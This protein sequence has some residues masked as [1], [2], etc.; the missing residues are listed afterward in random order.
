MIVCVWGLR[1]LGALYG[2]HFFPNI[3]LKKN[4]PHSLYGSALAHRGVVKAKLTSL[5]SASAVLKVPVRRIVSLSKPGRPLCLGAALTT[6]YRSHGLDSSVLYDIAY[7]SQNIGGTALTAVV[8]SRSGTT[9]SFLSPIIAFYWNLR[10]GRESVDLL[11]YVKR[12]HWQSRLWHQTLHSPRLSF[13]A[14]IFLVLGTIYVKIVDFFK[15]PQFND[16]AFKLWNFSFGGVYLIYLIVKKIALVF[17]NI[18]YIPVLLVFLFRYF[19]YLYKT[20]NSL[21][22]AFSI[23]FRDSVSVCG[24]FLRGLSFKLLP[25]KRVGFSYATLHLLY[26]NSSNSPLSDDYI[27][28]GGVFS[29][30]DFIGH[31]ESTGLG[32]GSADFYPVSWLDIPY[33]LELAY[34]GTKFFVWQ[35]RYLKDPQILEYLQRSLPLYEQ[36]LSQ[37]VQR[38]SNQF[39]LTPQFFDRLHPALLRQFC[40]YISNCVIQDPLFFLRVEV[41]GDDFLRKVFLQFLQQVELAKHPDLFVWLDQV[42]IEKLFKFNNYSWIQRLDWLLFRPGLPLRFDLRVLSH[43]DSVGEVMADPFMYLSN[44]SLVADNRLAGFILSLGLHYSSPIIYDTDTIDPGSNYGLF[45]CFFIVAAILPGWFFHQILLDRH[46]QIFEERVMQQLLKVDVHEK[47]VNMDEELEDFEDETEEELDEEDVPLYDEE[48]SS[49]LDEDEDENELDDWEEYNEVDFLSSE[50]EAIAE[51]LVR[52]NMREYNL[53]RLLQSLIEIWEPY[54]NDYEFGTF[55]GQTLFAVKWRKRIASWG[56]WLLSLPIYGRFQHGLE[57]KL[58]SILEDFFPDN[59]EI[60]QQDDVAEMARHA[61]WRSSYKQ[62]SIFRQYF[63]PFLLEWVEFFYMVRWQI[64][65]SMTE[66]DDIFFEGRAY[67]DYVRRRFMFNSHDFDDFLNTYESYVFIILFGL[68]SYL[69]PQAIYFATSA[70]DEATYEETFLPSSVDKHLIPLEYRFDYLLM[71]WASDFDVELSVEG[72][73]CTSPALAVSEVHQNPIDSYTQL[74]ASPLLVPT[75]MEWLM[76]EITAEL[77]GHWWEDPTTFSELW[78]EKGLIDDPIMRSS[79]NL[80]YNTIGTQTIADFTTQ[81]GDTFIDNFVASRAR[82]RTMTPQEDYNKDEEQKQD[83]WEWFR[84]ITIRIDHRKSFVN[85]IEA[86]QHFFTGISSLRQLNTMWPGASYE[87]GIAA[88]LFEGIGDSFFDRIFSQKKLSNLFTFDKDIWFRGGASPYYTI[89]FHSGLFTANLSPYI[90]SFVSETG[91]LQHKQ[92]LSSEFGYK[93]SGFA[94]VEEYF[95]FWWTMHKYFV[96]KIPVLR[97][98]ASLPSDIEGRLGWHENEAIS[99]LRQGQSRLLTNNLSFSD[100][101]ESYLIKYFGVD[102]F[103]AKNARSSGLVLEASRIVINRKNVQLIFFNYISKVRGEWLWRKFLTRSSKFYSSHRGWLLRHRTQLM[104]P[105]TDRNSSEL[106]FDPQSEDEDFIDWF[107]KDFEI[108]YPARLHRVLRS[109]FVFVRPVRYRNPELRGFFS[110]TDYYVMPDARDYY[111]R[112]L[113]WLSPIPAYAI[114]DKQVPLVDVSIFY[115]IHRKFMQLQLATSMPNRFRKNWADDFKVSIRAVAMR[116][117]NSMRIKPADPVWSNA[118]GWLDRKAWYI[119]VN[120]YF[121]GLLGWIGFDNAWFERSDLLHHYENLNDVYSYASI[122]P[123]SLFSGPTFYRA[124]FFKNYFYTE[125]IRYARDLVSRGKVRRAPTKFS[126]RFV[127]MYDRTQQIDENLPDNVIVKEFFRLAG[128]FEK[129]HDLTF[130]SRFL[131]WTSFGYETY[132]RAF[133]YIQSLQTPE[134]L[135][136]H[137]VYYYNMVNHFVPNFLRMAGL[138]SD[139]L[140]KRGSYFFEILRDRRQNYQ[141]LRNLF[142]RK[143]I[144]KPQSHY[145]G[146]QKG[147]YGGAKRRKINFSDLSF[148]DMSNFQDLP[149]VSPFEFKMEL[150]PNANEIYWVFQNNF[151]F[152]HFRHLDSWLVSYSFLYKLMHKLIAVFF[153]TFVFVPLNFVKLTQ[154]SFYMLGTGLWQRTRA[155]FWFAIQSFYLEAYINDLYHNDIDATGWTFIWRYLLRLL[156]SNWL[157]LIKQDAFGYIKWFWALIAHLRHALWQY[158]R[159][160]RFSTVYQQ[161]KTHLI[162][163]YYMWFQLFAYSINNFVSPMIKR[164]DLLIANFFDFCFSFL[165]R[166]FYVDFPVTICW[167]VLAAG[168]FNVAFFGSFLDAYM[169]LKVLYSSLFRLD[170]EQTFSLVAGLLQGYY[171][172]YY[173]TFRRF[174]VQ[175]DVGAERLAQQD[176]ALFLLYRRALPYASNL[177]G[178]FKDWLI[179]MGKGEGAFYELFADPSIYQRDR[180]HREYANFWLLRQSLPYRRYSVSFPGDINSVLKF[181]KDIPDEYM[182]DFM[183]SYIFN[184]FYFRKNLTNNLDTVVKLLEGLP[185]NLVLQFT[186]RYERDVIINQ[187]WHPEAKKTAYAAQNALWWFNFDSMWDDFVYSDKKFREEQQ[188]LNAHWTDE[189]F[190]WSRYSDR[191]WKN[192][193]NIL[194]IRRRF[195]WGEIRRICDTCEMP[196]VWRSKILEN[197]DKEVQRVSFRFNPVTV[198]QAFS[199]TLDFEFPRQLQVYRTIRNDQVFVNEE[200][201]QC[202]SDV[203]QPVGLGLLNPLYR[204]L[205]LGA[206]DKAFFD[207]SYYLPQYTSRFL[208]SVLFTKYPQTEQRPWRTRY[209]YDFLRSYLQSRQVFYRGV[210]NNRSRFFHFP[211]DVDRTELRPWSL[212]DPYY[213]YNLLY[214]PKS[215]FL[216]DGYTS[217]SIRLASRADYW[218]ST[219]N[220]MQ[221]KTDEFYSW[222]TTYTADST[223]RP[224]RGRNRNTPFL[225]NKPRYPD[226]RYRYGMVSHVEGM[227][228]GS[229]VSPGAEEI[230]YVANYF[231]PGAF[232]LQHHFEFLSEP[233]LPDEEGFLQQWDDFYKLPESQVDT[234][235]FNPLLESQTFAA[236]RRLEEFDVHYSRFWEDQVVPHSG[237]WVGNEGSDSLMNESLDSE[238]DDIYY[239]W[240]GSIFMEPPADIYEL[241]EFMEDDDDGFDFFSPYTT[242]RYTRHTVNTTGGSKYIQGKEDSAPP[243]IF[244]RPHKPFLSLNELATSTFYAA[245]RTLN[246]LGTEQVDYKNASYVNRTYSLH[247]RDYFGILKDFLHGRSFELLFGMPQNRNL[248]ESTHYQSNQPALPLPQKWIPLL[249]NMAYWNKLNVMPEISW[250]MVFSFIIPSRNYFI[251]VVKILVPDIAYLAAKGQNISYEQV[252]LGI[253]MPDILVKSSANWDK[254]MAHAIMHLYNKHKID[255]VSYLYHQYLYH[256]N[257]GKPLSFLYHDELIEFY[258]GRF[259]NTNVIGLMQSRLY[260]G[261]HKEGFRIFYFDKRP[262]WD[263]V[264]AFVSGDPFYAA[265]FNVVSPD[266]LMSF[267]EWEGLLLLLSF[268]GFFRFIKLFV[269]LGAIFCYLLFSV[270]FFVIGLTS[271]PSVSDF[272]FF[273]FYVHFVLERS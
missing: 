78:W 182:H 192:L 85:E 68:S 96:Q 112:H 36:N 166:P 57:Q 94:V 206:D 136:A 150:R 137:R 2:F 227:A 212:R 131:S 157:V 53:H 25:I 260:P 146:L 176:V 133:R 104:D 72:F 226:L 221:T 208:D 144:G 115:S 165:V 187:A 181:L 265:C 90:D 89:P 173:L 160:H 159:L 42:Y 213:H 211:Y 43:L 41:L 107:D 266:N 22:F 20:T 73:Y 197:F 29:S 4:E 69:D 205:P 47:F 219:L 120:G 45:F 216:N 214:T 256:Y 124:S 174:I 259:F 236:N 40:D 9:M 250:N 251:D 52:L 167:W 177:Y 178:N 225:I 202:K 138:G 87:P 235:S 95:P 11:N 218:D 156:Y 134:S 143:I 222:P 145:K 5:C 204:Q 19:L 119:T 179:A 35:E 186:M 243:L 190:S 26:M 28:S 210:V 116:K 154:L 263:V 13:W 62:S 231:D 189:D 130:T 268:S 239:N 234:V 10:L 117:F 126:D 108:L 258:S 27:S 129:K 121:Q 171:R 58:S 269:A 158:F 247:H 67:S 184:V 37:Y 7:F 114:V 83:G 193:N 169:W 170:L 248:A 48:T 230:T 245:Y 24:E 32:T 91:L 60:W 21:F 163:E 77:F 164:L 31:L 155:L 254:T 71:D 152:N 74:A 209:Y 15:S 196:A 123:S 253:G 255:V 272:N 17:D 111:M 105:D 34:T 79:S 110:F 55:G 246:Q 46:L 147:L 180:L 81:T 30:L 242:M 122:T 151:I 33:L 240:N 217:S 84:Y 54:F 261:Y 149:V 132:P 199:D 92:M 63:I 64:Y 103:Q 252:L 1:R 65:D 70:D 128:N 267:K 262:K 100:Y 142:W 97:T 86:Q 8:V 175:Q 237:F 188:K 93:A 23:F 264:P 56:Y 220:W 153:Y 229:G 106:D 273:L 224:N 127:N 270:F 101:L 185:A 241:E 232:G 12:H 198:E 80:L 88:A 59:R 207:V 109:P 249:Y 139:H 102:C 141:E 168:R 50:H 140:Y 201:N 223:Q 16:W 135:Q 14:N 44:E 3:I 244:S 191:V 39:Y 118:W 200:H 238:G 215:Y 228:S 99:A 203:F 125:Q 18:K 82:L 38:G 6:P 49:E 195:D 66:D 257:S 51:D 271:V 172:D 162:A 194:H 61:V 113:H 98:A 233:I 76:P 161:L 75:G 183:E 148:F